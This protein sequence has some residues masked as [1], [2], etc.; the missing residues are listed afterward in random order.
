MARHPGARGV[1][2]RSRSPEASADP[3]RPLP[4][5]P[6]LPLQPFRFGYHYT[7]FWY[8]IDP[9]PPHAILATSGEFCLSAKVGKEGCNVL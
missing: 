4:P 1:G 7:H 8:T 2:R 3:S 9:R 5:L 6:P